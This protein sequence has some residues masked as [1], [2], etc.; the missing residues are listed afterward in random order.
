MVGMHTNQRAPHT[1][2][3][4]M[5]AAILL[6]AA[7]CSSSS[8]DTGSAVS[9]AED[10]STEETSTDDTS[11][12]PAGEAT[13]DAP[14]EASIDADDEA[15]AEPDEAADE[16]APPADAGDSTTS[17][18]V[19]S[20]YL[21]SYELADEEFGT[22]VT[23]TVEGTTRTIASNS[24]P[25]HETGDFPNAGNPNEI[26]EQELNY[27]FTTAPV[28]T[29]NATFAQT[30]GVG[31]NG[32]A[33]EPGTGE[34]VSC[35]SG[36]S[37]R[38]EALQDLYNLGLDVNNAHVQPDG[39][40]HYH[41]LS[42]FLVAAFDSDEDLVHVGF[43][44]DGFLMYYSKSGAFDTGYSLAT[45]PRTGT[46]C[47]YRGE[48]VEVDGTMPDGTYVSDWV[49]T[50][51]GDLDECMGT[52][53]NGEYVYV[54]GE[55]YP[56]I[57]RCLNGE[58]TGGGPGAGGAP[59]EGA[60]GAAGEGAAGP[61]DLDAAAAEL[62]ISVDELMAALGGPPPDLDATAATLGIS[63]EELAAALGV[64]TN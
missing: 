29:G 39:Q 24:L 31:V 13:E 18:V 8:T 44:A 42:Q 30:S 15:G 19:A 38:I 10:A 25:N 34:T 27:E 14:A 6:L 60:E 40:Y 22:M 57:S 50:D 16:A 7:A 64:P 43:A 61:P 11:T 48:T 51:A 35:E 3:L 37:Y 62:G 53:V 45:E 5:I 47:T 59:P 32:I 26:S 12:E 46:D 36:E 2:L 20:D 23:V 56:Y 17:T 63:V 55:Q 1:R 4:A 58:V 33:M 52:E 28:Y 54:I 41:G 9:D 21:G 49:H